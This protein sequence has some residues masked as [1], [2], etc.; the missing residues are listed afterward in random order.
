M[1]ELEELRTLQNDSGTPVRRRRLLADIAREHPTLLFTLGYIAL[2]AVGLVYDAWLYG[3]FRINVIEYSETSDFLLAAVRTPLVIILSILPVLILW[4]VTRL[5]RKARR[6]FPRYDKWSRRYEG[7]IW[8]MENPRVG[9]PI[10]VIFVVIYAILFTQLYAL[11]VADKIKAGH[12]RVVKVEMIVPGSV[13]TA[14]TTLLIGTTG[15]FVFLFDPRAN[16]TRIIPF[17]NVSS[18]SVVARRKR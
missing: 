16:Q 18:I 13:P 3:Y 6:T 7:T 4:T 5:R 12:G 14:D 9:G 1:P 2:T 17:D 8:D 10:G 15:K 11:R